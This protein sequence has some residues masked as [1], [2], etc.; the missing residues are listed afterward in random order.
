MVGA[1]VASGVLMAAPAHADDPP[2]GPCTP[3]DASPPFF[4]INST[5][6]N[7]VLTHFLSFNVTDGTTGE[8]TYTLSKVNTVTT[9]IGSSTEISASAGQLFA[10]VSVKVGFSVQRQTSTTDTESTTMKWTFAKPDYYALYKGTRAVSGTFREWNC[11]RSPGSPTGYIWS[12][13]R[14]PLP[15]TTFGNVEEGTLTCGDQVPAGSL[16]LLARLQLGC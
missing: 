5:E 7:P 2:S 15:F 11:N 12:A 8:H 9:T 10:K 4:Q 13:R 14:T 1:V 3:G 16:R 6:V